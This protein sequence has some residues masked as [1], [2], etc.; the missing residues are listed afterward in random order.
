[1][2]I[3]GRL[4]KGIKL[5]FTALKIKISPNFLVWN[6]VET[7]TFRLVSEEL[8]KTL[9]KFFAFPQNFHFGRIG[10]L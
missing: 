2:E 10:E 5:N 4:I 6:I 7:H 1:M 8:S 9:R 3:F